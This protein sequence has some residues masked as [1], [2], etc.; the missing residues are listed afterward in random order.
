MTN[1]PLLA[2]LC[3]VGLACGQWLF[4]HAANLMATGHPALSGGVLMT[5]SIAFATYVITTLA[6]V[7]LLQKND[8]GRLYPFMALAFVF[9]PIG[10]YFFFGERFT[11]YYLLGIALIIA[12]IVIIAR[13]T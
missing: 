4:K 5:L 8:L 3:V 12:G 6:W 1:A 7:W 13:T 11:P 10:S 9:V 2:V